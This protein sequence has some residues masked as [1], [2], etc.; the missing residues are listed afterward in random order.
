MTADGP[1]LFDPACYWGDRECD[2]AMLPLYPELPPQIY[3]GY[4]SVWPLESGFIE[5]QPLINCITC[6]TAVTCSA[7]SIWFGPNAR[8]KRCC[9]PSPDKIKALKSAPF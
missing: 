4:Q 1:L 3:D 5:R 2:L 8:W 6:S 9:I 7:G